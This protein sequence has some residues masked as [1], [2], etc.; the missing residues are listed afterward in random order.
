[1]GKGRG[2]NQGTLTK[3]WPPRRLATRR[4]RGA[5]QVA[6]RSGLK[7]ES[8]SRKPQKSPA[9]P[10]HRWPPR[11][12]SLRPLRAPDSWD[13][14]NA[15]GSP[16]PGRKLRPNGVQAAAGGREGGRGGGRESGRGGPGMFPV[17]GDCARG[18]DPAIGGSGGVG[19]CPGTFT[20]ERASWGSDYRKRPPWLMINARGPPCGSCWPPPLTTWNSRI[21]KRTWWGY[22]RVTA[23]ISRREGSQSLQTGFRLERTPSP[24]TWTFPA[25]TPVWMARTSG[26]YWSRSP[27]P[28]D[29]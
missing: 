8:R 18:C 27:R 17:G 1:M 2:A 6:P 23:L 14:R 16:A 12:P 24:A 28:T 4:A 9:A 29:R 22:S 15:H 10:A 25:D 13:P 21:P 7:F 26:S 3:R 19:G 20:A 11:G 5:A